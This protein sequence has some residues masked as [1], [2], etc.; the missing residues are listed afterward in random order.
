MPNAKVFLIWELKNKGIILKQ[1]PKH[2]VCTVSLNPL[3]FQIIAIASKC[4]C[5]HLLSSGAAGDL[6]AKN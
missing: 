2:G 3:T 4:F 1:I 6:L 5:R